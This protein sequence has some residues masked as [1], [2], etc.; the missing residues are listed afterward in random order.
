MT[1]RTKERAREREKR[2][3]LTNYEQ[4]FIDKFRLEC[5][6]FTQNDSFNHLMG[7]FAWLT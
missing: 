5:A 1:N 3:R 7:V 6:P 2:E 4:F